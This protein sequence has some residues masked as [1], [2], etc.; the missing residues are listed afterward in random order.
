[1]VRHGNREGGQCLWYGPVTKG[2][3]GGKNGQ[4]LRDVLYGRP[5]T[6]F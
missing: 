1:M 5:Q 3:G 6:N 2:G 4:N